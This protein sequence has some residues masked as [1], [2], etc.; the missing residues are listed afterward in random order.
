[1]SWCPRCGCRGRWR[2]WRQGW[3]RAQRLLAVG[4]CARLA[5]RPRLENIALRARDMGRVFGREIDQHRRERRVVLHVVKTDLVVSVT[6]RMP[7]VPAVVPVTR[8]EIE[9]GS[10]AGH[11]R[12]VIRP[13]AA[14]RAGKTELD[15]ARNIGR[16]A[17]EVPRQVCRGVRE[18]GCAHVLD[19]A[20]SVILVE[21]RLQSR[22]DVGMILYEAA[23]TVEALLLTAPVAD[24]NRA[25]RLGIELLQNSHRF[26]H[27]DR[28]GTI[29]GGA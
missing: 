27:R 21:Q 15:V 13:A 26:E 12:G 16:H 11:E 22:D 7:C 4:P 5:A 23:R 28:A 20:R 3:R 9:A 1:M 14:W 24:E 8:S 6:V 2:S 17:C 25:P 10:A 29:V 19:P 18:T